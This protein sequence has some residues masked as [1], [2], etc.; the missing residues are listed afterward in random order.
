[1]LFSYIYLCTYIYICQ[2]RAQRTYAFYIYEISSTKNEY[3]NPHLHVGL[4]IPNSQFGSIRAASC[5]LYLGFDL[6]N[7]HSMSLTHNSPLQQH[8]PFHPRCCKDNS[9][10]DED[11]NMFLGSCDGGYGLR[12]KQDCQVHRERCHTGGNIPKRPG[13]RKR[14]LQITHTFASSGRS[15]QRS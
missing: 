10:H 1:M 12:T 11:S 7:V 6:I 4:T 13:A 8:N 14:S 3:A 5:P 15:V 9:Y 2:H